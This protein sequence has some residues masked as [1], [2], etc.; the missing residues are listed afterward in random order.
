MAAGGPDMSTSSNAQHTSVMSTMPTRLASLM[1][2]PMTRAA[3]PAG[4]EQDW[5]YRSSM[6][7]VQ[8]HVQQ[9]S[10]LTS[11]SHRSRNGPELPKRPSMTCMRL[12]CIRRIKSSFLITVVAR[13]ELNSRS[14]GRI[15]LAVLSLAGVDQ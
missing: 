10:R 15:L 5:R 12:V 4:H 7:A 9:P 13:H 8:Q 1:T 6:L 14:R 3:V 2:S 11:D